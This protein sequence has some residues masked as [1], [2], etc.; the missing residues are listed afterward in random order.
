MSASIHV[1]SPNV[2]Y[3]DTHIEAHYSYQ[4][5]SVRQEGNR[6]TVSTTIVMNTDSTITANVRLRTDCRLS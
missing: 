3:T 4:A 1:N 2:K 5:S 6:V